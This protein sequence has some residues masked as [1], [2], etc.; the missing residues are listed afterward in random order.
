MQLQTSTERSIGSG[1]PYSFLQLLSLFTYRDPKPMLN[2]GPP[3]VTATQKPSFPLESHKSSLYHLILVTGHVCLIW[4]TG[5][6]LLWASN[7]TPGSSFSKIL[8]QGLSSSAYN[9]SHIKIWNGSDWL[10]K[11]TLI[12]P[13]AGPKEPKKECTDHVSDSKEWDRPQWANDLPR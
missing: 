4:V 7:F 12:K 1:Y 11:N 2:G 6:W 13:N 10:T 3:G 9:K 5:T 8:P